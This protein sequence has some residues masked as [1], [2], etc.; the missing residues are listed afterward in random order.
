MA[1]PMMGK[2]GSAPRPKTQVSAADRAAQAAGF[3]NAAEQ[4]ANRQMRNQLEMKA[5]M[6][7]I[8]NQEA[9]KLVKGPLTNTGALQE[10][11]NK[12]GTG[13]RPAP[14]PA[15]KAAP[16]P[17]PSAESTRYRDEAAN[18]MRQA[19]E[20]LNQFKIEQQ[21]AAEAARLAEEMRIKSQASLAANMARSQQTPNLQI[22]PA[23]GTPQTAGTQPFKRRRGDMMTTTPGGLS[24]LNIA[25]PSTLNV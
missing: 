18:Y 6:A 3:A 24:A 25:S 4:Q 9:Y 1:I 19:Q 13:G 16:A 17:R 7:G 12:I 15:P 10:A 21:R 22:Q 20:M 5:A 11:W 14:A 23:S 2:W 8:S